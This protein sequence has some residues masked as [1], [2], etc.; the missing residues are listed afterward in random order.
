MRQR[1][2]GPRIEEP[3]LLHREKR[4]ARRRQQDLLYLRLPP[5]LQTLEDRRVLRI[6]GYYAFTVGKGH[7]PLAAGDERFFV[8]EGHAVSGLERPDRGGESSEA[9]YAVKD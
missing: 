4:S 3:R 9:D 7:D 8:G 1:I 5:P 2:L 6:Y